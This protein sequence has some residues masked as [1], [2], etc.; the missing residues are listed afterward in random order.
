MYEAIKSKIKARCVTL[1][2][3][4]MFKQWNGVK[5]VLRSICMLF[6]TYFAYLPIL[7]IRPWNLVYASSGCYRGGRYAW[8]GVN[9]TSRSVAMAESQNWGRTGVVGRKGVTGLQA[10][11]SLTTKG[12][13]PNIVE[14]RI[15]GFRWRI[16]MA[17]DGSL[18]RWDQGPND[19]D[20]GKVRSLYVLDPMRRSSRELCHNLCIS[21]FFKLFYLTTTTFGAVVAIS[22][23]CSS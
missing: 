21:Q 4:T 17:F 7:G 20:I 15:F 14:P 10:W 1:T 12:G 19:N 9:R 11:S 2:N 18:E 3:Y 16:Q 22:V 13:I 8:N 5:G 6:S 23:P